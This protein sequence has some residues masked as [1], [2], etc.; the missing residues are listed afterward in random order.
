MH[1]KMRAPVDARYFPRGG[2]GDVELDAMGVF[3]SV[4]HGD[5]E[6]FF[7]DKIR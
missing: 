6:L 4:G 3:C 2:V 5:H 7:D 1:S